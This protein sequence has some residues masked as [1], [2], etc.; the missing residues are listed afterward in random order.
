LAYGIPLW[1]L[2]FRAPAGPQVAASLTVAIM[3]WLMFAE[4][5]WLSARLLLTKTRASAGDRR[6]PEFGR[7]V[8][9]I[10]II[11]VGMAYWLGSQKQNLFAPQYLARLVQQKYTSPPDLQPLN[12]PR[13]GSSRLPAEQAKMVQGITGR[14]HRELGP[15]DSLFVFPDM[16]IFSFLSDRKSMGRFSVPLMAALTEGHARELLQTLNDQPPDWVV[17]NPR[18]S[19]LAVSVHKKEEELMPE[20]VNFIRENYEV[21]DSCEGVEIMVRKGKKDILRPDSRDCRGN[22][23][24]LVSDTNLFE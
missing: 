5:F 12:D 16:A 17:Y 4:Q 22:G 3:L 19:G 24:V 2:S 9:C 1:L 7:A 18:Q 10:L 15:E 14:L 21:V 23:T 8:V 13:M 11:V 20:V 6:S